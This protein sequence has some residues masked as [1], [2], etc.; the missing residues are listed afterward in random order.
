MTALGCSRALGR[1]GRGGAFR[2]APRPHGCW[3]ST[4]RLP[5]SPPRGDPRQGPR[6]ALT[7]LRARAARP[8]TAL[9]APAGAGRLRYLGVHPPLL[10]GA[11][12]PVVHQLQ[13]VL[14]LLGGPGVVLGPHRRARALLTATAASGAG[15]SGSATPL[16]RPAAVATQ[17]MRARGPPPPSR[18][19]ARVLPSLLTFNSS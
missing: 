18:G 9:P 7:L 8:G 11:R 3:D 14:R 15:S 10:A 1:V 16:F 13:P 17:R 12:G 2:T 6:P 4:R 5:P 19:T